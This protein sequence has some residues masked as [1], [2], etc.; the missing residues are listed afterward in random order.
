MRV[1]KEDSLLQ[2]SDIDLVNK[3]VDFIKLNPFPTDKDF[4]KF[5]QSN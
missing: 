1:F 4:H 3:I 2:L 5:A